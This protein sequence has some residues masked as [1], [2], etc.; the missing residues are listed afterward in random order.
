M[1][2]VSKFSKL[3]NFVKAGFKNASEKDGLTGILEYT[4]KR[5]KIDHRVNQ[6]IGPQH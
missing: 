2:L 3:N 5:D 1:D 6:P 4:Y